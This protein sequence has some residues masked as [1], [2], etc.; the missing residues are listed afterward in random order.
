MFS[1]D[2]L[3]VGE[4]PLSVKRLGK[5]AISPADGATIERF[6]AGYEIE[7]IHK[8]EFFCR[9]ATHTGPD[10]KVVGPEK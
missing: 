6:P 4:S 8:A 3:E 10:E 1:V 9:S 2:A 7:R 5:N